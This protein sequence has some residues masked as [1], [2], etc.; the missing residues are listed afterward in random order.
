MPIR[1]TVMFE[2]QVISLEEFY[3]I[4]SARPQPTAAQHEQAAAAD[5]FAASYNLPY[6]YNG[7]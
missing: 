2:G 4:Q 7:D 5:D 6:R 3:R 1:Q